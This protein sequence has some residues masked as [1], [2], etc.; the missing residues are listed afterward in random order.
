MGIHDGEFVLHHVKRLNHLDAAGFNVPSTITSILA[1]PLALYTGDD[2]GRVV[3]C[4]SP[5]VM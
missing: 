5:G 1:M 2:D 3:S 4:L